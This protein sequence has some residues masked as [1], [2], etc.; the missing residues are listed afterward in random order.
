MNLIHVDTYLSISSTFTVIG[1]GKSYKN[2][3]T[4]IKK[5]SLL[6]YF[7]L[8]FIISWAGIIFASFFMG[9]PTTSK[10][11]AEDGP[12]ALMPFLFG[13]TIVGLILIGI[14]HGKNGFKEL[15][16]RFLKWKIN[17]R[18]YIFTLFMLPSILSVMLLVLSQFSSDFT[19]KVMNETDKVTFVITG[20]F[21]GFIGGGILEEIGWT[22]FA[23][24]ELRKRYSTLKSGLILGF[25][26]AVWHFLPVLWGSGDANGN[27]D[28]SIFLPG[29]FCHY[30]VLVSYRVLMVWVH[31]KTKS[32]IPI[33]FMHGVLGAF[34]N[35]ILNI[36]VGGWPLFSYFLILAIALCA[37]VVIIL[38][39]DNKKI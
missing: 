12:L 30:T 22:G 14:V 13:P 29:L 38:S 7:V 18:W 26:W 27:V 10:Q 25:I 1:D 3:K 4:L 34:A 5:K 33:I 35:F 36:S 23:T 37:I 28:W 15:L 8:T 2:M 32:M 16:S 21:L 24:P 9:M 11:F 17:L 31:D 6:V 39:K 20:L 19:P